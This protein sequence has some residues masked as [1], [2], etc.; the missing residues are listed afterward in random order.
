MIWAAGTTARFLVNEG[1][2][3]VDPSL[4]RGVAD[5]DL[6]NLAFLAEVTAGLVAYVGQE[7][8]FV[9]RREWESMYAAWIEPA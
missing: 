4:V 2:E 9:P 3:S 6:D 5:V 1:P 7:A 8:T